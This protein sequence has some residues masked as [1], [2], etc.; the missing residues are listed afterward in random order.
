MLVELGPEV[1]HPARRAGG[2]SGARGRTARRP[3]MSAER[4]VEQV[5]VGRARP[6]VDDAVGDLDQPARPD[7]ARDRLAARLAGAEPGQQ[8]GQV[9]DAGAVVGDDDRAR[10]DVGAG[11]AERLEVVRRVEQVGREQA[12]RRPADE[13]GLDRAAGRQR[14]AERRRSSRS[15]VPS[16]TSAMPSPAGVRTWTRI[17]PGLSL[18]ADR[19]RTPSAPLRMIHGDGGQRLDVVDDGRH[20]RT[21]R[22]RRGAAAAARAG[23]A[24]PRAP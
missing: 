11:L 4:S 24:C 13:D 7:P 2:S 21:G 3:T 1:S 15:G 17:V 9:D 6:A 16:G 5:E 10:A 8:P 22:A 19:R 14:A 18:R 12:A 20:A 23:R